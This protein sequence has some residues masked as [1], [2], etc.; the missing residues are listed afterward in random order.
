[1]KT[2]NLLILGVLAYAV[3]APTTAAAQTPT[4]IK[5]AKKTALTKTKAKAKKPVAKKKTT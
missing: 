2:S 5:A 1:M 3:F 4:K